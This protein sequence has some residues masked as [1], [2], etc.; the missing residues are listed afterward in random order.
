MLRK[1]GDQAN[2]LIFLK[3]L[4][5]RIKV[6]TAC[7]PL[8]FL[9]A[10]FLIKGPP[11]SLEYYNLDWRKSEKIKIRRLPIPSGCCTDQNQAVA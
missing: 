4:V 11:H 3:V 6:Y 8:N 10:P 1:S 5:R 9:W 7:N 2:Y